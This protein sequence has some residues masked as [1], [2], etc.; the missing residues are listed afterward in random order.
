TLPIHR[1]ARAAARR[2][3][4]GWRCCSGR[5]R[6]ARFADGVKGT[7]DLRIGRRAVGQ[8]DAL[9]L[10]GVDQPQLL[11]RPVGDLQLLAKAVA[12]GRPQLRTNSSW[13]SSTESD[14]AAC[15]ADAWSVT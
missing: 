8:K 5:C 4:G 12:V 11:H 15:C 2:R 10:V 14:R 7:G 6:P 9:L 1:T 3:G 13:V